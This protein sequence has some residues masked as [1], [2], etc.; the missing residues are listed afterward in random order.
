MSMIET[1]GNVR[2]NMDDY[3]GE[4]LYSD[5]KV[6]DELLEIARSYDPADFDR[7]VAERKSWP[8]MYH[9]SKIRQNI[10]AWYPGIEGKRVL[11]IGSGC[12]AVT[13]EL[14]RRA[15]SVTCVELSKK[16]SL[17][18][19]YRNRD[20]GNLE[21][22]LGNFEDVEK[23]LPC[24]YDVIT[25]IG[26]F[27]YGVNYIHSGEPYQDFLRAIR[28]HLKADG[29][30]L[31]AI[32]NRM[33]LKYFAG[34]TED[35]TGGFFDGIEGYGKTE[36]VRTFARPE[37]EKICREAG[38]E[39]LSFY[40]PYP[41]YKFPMS[42][43]S[44]HYLPKSGELRSNIV[45][46]DRKRLILFDEAKAF[47]AMA[48]S[49]LF[50]QFSNSF[51]IV[52]E[53]GGNVEACRERVIFSKFS[54]E[55]DPAWAIRTDIAVRD[56]DTAA[57]EMIRADEGAEGV[58][59][60]PA[61]AEV[62]V[63]RKAPAD[64]GAKAHI[65][66]L[67]KCYEGLRK[68]YEG[69]RF[70]PNHL[71]MEDGAAVFEFLS[72]ETLEERF[73]RAYAEGT[74]RLKEAFSGYFAE[75]DQTADTAFQESDGFRKVFG[76]GGGLEG[77]P[78][79]SISNIDL[80]LNNVLV[81]EAGGKWNVIDYEWTFLF[82]VPLSYIKWR[83]LHYYIEGNTKRFGL[84]EAGLFESAGLDADSIAVF[85]RMEQCFQDYIEGKWTP[86]RE[87]YADISE[88]AVDLP[89]IL[90][91]M[92]GARGGEA[93][94][95]LYLDRGKGFR[96]EDTVLLPHGEDGRISVAQEL[97]GLKGL[98]IDPA[99]Y[100][101]VVTVEDIGTE[102]GPIDPGRLASNGVRLD[103]RRFLFDTDD[104][105]LIVEGWPE[106]AHFLYAHLRMASMDVDSAEFMR[107]ELDVRDTR[108][109]E[110]LAAD[111]RKE[112]LLGWRGE[113]IRQ[114]MKTAPMKAYRKLRVKAKRKDP[115]AM[116]RPLLPSDPK[117]ILYC[118][119][120]AAHRKSEYFLRGWCFDREYSA[121]RVY[122]VNAKDEVIPAK[123]DRYRRPDVAKQ[124]GLPEEREMGFSVSIPYEAVRNLPLY[125]EVENPRGY[126]C[127]K[128]EIAL[129][130]K[131]QEAANAAL[132]QKES[133]SHEISGYEDWAVAHAVS[134]EEKSAQRNEPDDPALKFS[135]AVPLYR[136][137][138]TLLR[139][140]VDSVRAQT[141]GNW[142]LLLTDGSGAPSPL[143]KILQ[144]LAGR[145]SRIVPLFHEERLRIAENTNAAL[146]KASGQ[147]IVFADHDDL[148]TED[149]L[150]ELARVIHAYPDVE[151]IYSDEDK[152]L[153]GG[154]LGE[155]N[156]K[157][158][159]SPDFLT[160]VNYICHLTAVSRSLLERTGFLDPAYEGAQDYDFVLR[161]SEQTDK[162]RHIPKVLYHWRMT[163]DSTAAN[164]E[165][166]EYAFSAG[167]RAIEAHLGRLGIEAAVL[168]GSHDGT[169]RVKER[170]LGEPLVSIV[171][172]NKD[173]FSDLE[174]C[175][176]SIE[177]KSAYK[178]RE[179]VIVENNS[180]EQETF[181]GYESLKA[182]YSDVRVVK[183]EGATTWVRG[184]LRG[185]TCSSSTMTRSSSAPMP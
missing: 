61:D 108:I 185:S 114:M 18:N 176:R 81:D 94:A 149:A 105:Y 160:S 115:Y 95:K 119:D 34:C 111:R 12:G 170:V 109:L 68:V 43:Y 77:S 38:F 134:E 164:P 169:Y 122:V 165:A 155:P 1:I 107:K 83:A 141:Y 9:F 33:G 78:A 183:Y 70:V 91:R 36:Y 135:L 58:R 139:E 128:L 154:V 62:R 10:L 16:R 8:V 138:P 6:E 26:V 39:N 54:N 103:L 88:G 2:M 40:Y 52:L 152:Y 140:L 74:A 63:V 41:D 45:N 173:H 69:T 84:R 79:C 167:V 64:A 28:K 93:M 66:G 136:T 47:D 127:E 132:R 174:R 177:E 19:A 85:E 22:R 76:D 32:E 156:F 142:E 80:V 56:A 4:D 163:E 49:G 113:V 21:I 82:P 11:E 166:K 53:N 59:K 110:L 89:A 181:A 46:F 147:W 71:E 180:T 117:G 75:M 102:L 130:P 179:F 87:L 57:V 14:A 171:I 50:P 112:E 25:L 123:V 20:A 101:G 17:I 35:H 72:G 44:D 159:F 133:A 29:K 3:P 153:P 104:P 143:A 5:G 150:Y 151:M 42:V 67:R 48:D 182:Q 98:R 175:V 172:P 121:E 148:L 96:E 23:K 125:L 15:E 31:I 116:L 137:D 7:V 99:E 145:D 131:E 13:G 184:K 51:F 65:E 97:E 24:D 178:R 92:N 73:D 124:F 129:D 120:H 55:R 157:P 144:T 90:K 37:I 158:D 168:R 162:I 86:L 106:D 161:C 30:V 146:Q 126:T 100:A 60:A 118:I 27:E